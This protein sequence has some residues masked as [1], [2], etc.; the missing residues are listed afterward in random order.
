M[1]C[2][3]L[4]GLRLWWWFWGLWRGRRWTWQEKISQT[5]SG[6]LHNWF[7]FY[8]ALVCIII[9]LFCPFTNKFDLEPWTSVRGVYAHCSFQNFEPCS[10]P[11]LIFCPLLSVPIFPVPIPFSLCNA[12][13]SYLFFSLPPIFIIGGFLIFF[14]NFSA[15][16]SFLQNHHLFVHSSVTY[17]GIAPCYFLPKR[18]WALLQDC[19]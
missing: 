8:I 9:V 1:L 6:K 14:N 10:L 15:S 17:F 7:I 12:P 3:K 5:K 2:Q 11:I 19:L 18:E 13:F 4:P 16:G